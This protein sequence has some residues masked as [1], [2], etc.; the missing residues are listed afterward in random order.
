MLHQYV[1][2]TLELIED[3]ILSRSL[4]L[5]TN[6]VGQSLLGAEHIRT[7][8]ANTDLKTRNMIEILYVHTFKVLNSFAFDESSS[9]FPIFKL[10]IFVVY[11]YRLQNS[12]MLLFKPSPINLSRVY[13]TPEGK[14]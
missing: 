1:T 9:Q 6:P 4:Q 14:L 11:S 13:G 3:L 2:S 10:Q 12:E 5:S 7:L 8:P